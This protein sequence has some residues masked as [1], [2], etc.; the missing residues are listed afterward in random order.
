MNM[1]VKNNSL[2]NT[3]FHDFINESV[4]PLFNREA[5]NPGEN[6]LDREVFWCEVDRLLNKYAALKNEKPLSLDKQT[7]AATQGV[8][9]QDVDEEIASLSGPQL[10]AQISRAEAAIG[11][12][13]ARWGS[14]F[15]T[16]KEEDAG[17]YG[18][19]FLDEIFPLKNGSHHDVA[20]YMVYYQHLL[21]VF[22]DGSSSGLANPCQ[23]VGLSGH[24]SEPTALLLKNNGLHIEIQINRKGLRGRTDLAGINDI[25]IEAALTAIMDFNTPSGDAELKVEGYRNYLQMMLGQLQDKNGMMLHHDKIFTDKNGTDMQ[26]HGRSLLLARCGDFQRECR[27]MQDKTGKD[28]SEGIIDT[29]VTAMIGAIDLQH[30]NRLLGNSRTNNIYFVKPRAMTSQAADVTCLLFRDI[31]SLLSLPEGTLKLVVRDDIEQLKAA[32]PLARER[33]VLVHT[34][35]SDH[36][37]ESQKRHA[38]PC[39]ATLHALQQHKPEMAKQ[40]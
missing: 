17:I 29:I 26:L 28:M 11:A 36:T 30:R 13:N 19:D 21:A 40:M 14:L 31:E 3:T 9:S 2:I 20:S 34:G 25:Q 33:M 38:S 16:M 10:T 22:N 18:K 35:M 7:A 27:L 23:F 4:L 39:V 24:K 32:N 8:N 37:G 6:K 15:D 1:P 12:A 5:L